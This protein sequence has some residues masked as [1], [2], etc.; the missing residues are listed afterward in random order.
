MN[1]LTAKELRILNGMSRVHDSSF[2]FGDKMAEIIGAVGESGTPVNAVAATDIFLITGVSIDGETLTINNPAVPGTDVY[3]F[4]AD[5][6]QT[7]TSPTNIAID[8]SALT[9]KATG[10]LTVD[11]QPTAGDTMW[12]GDKIYTFV[13]E[14]TANAEGE[15]SVGLDL[16]GAKLNI[17]AAINGTD[18]INNPATAVTAAAFVVNACVITALVGGTAGNSIPTTETF[19]AGTNVFA[20][21]TLGTGTNCTAVNTATALIAAITA[22]DTQGVGAAVGGGTNVALTADTAGV[23]GN[24]ITIADTMANGAMTAAATTLKAGV[25]GTVATGTKFL[26]D[27]TYLYTAL[28]GNTISQANWRRIALGAAF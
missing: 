17:V 4:L 27:A 10:T 8:I 1:A 25:N 26:L 19:T 24:A 11:T 14:G 28:G 5:A 6:A 9:G 13:P 7:K 21:V 16:A 15:V 3:E 18:G 22:S 2:K 12:I 20:A 23:V